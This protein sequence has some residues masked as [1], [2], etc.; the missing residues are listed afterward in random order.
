MTAD[1]TS[2]TRRLAFSGAAALVAA[3]ALLMAASWTRWKGACGPGLDSVA[4]L[5]VQ[6]HRFDYVL[7]SEPAGSI[8]LTTL[9]AGAAYVLLA[10]GL[11]LVFA[12]A[13]SAV[14]ARVLQGVLVGS[15]LGT[16]LVTLLSAGAGHSIGYEWVIVPW[17]MGPLL[18]AT[19]LADIVSQ[20]DDDAVMSDRAWCA[21]AGALVLAHPIIEFMLTPM[22]VR[23]QSHDTTPWDGMVG[24][25]AF[26]LA[27]LVVLGGLARTAAR[28]RQSAQ[29]EA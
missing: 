19:I 26:V 5:T 12:A 27:G 14:W 15:A 8:G 21:W 24:G 16:G 4:C 29:R 2:P 3:G 28:R 23:Y 11:A 1:G 20:G 25:A 10:A 17:L 22:M 6:D 9:F 18:I 7:P 13:R